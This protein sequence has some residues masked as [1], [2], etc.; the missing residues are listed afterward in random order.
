M[1]AYGYARV[2][3]N[4]QELGSQEA[5]LMAA[6][7]AK[8]FKEK[9]SGAKTD[10]AELAKVIRRLEAGDVLVVTR[11]DRLARSTHDLLNVL[12]TIGERQAS[13]RSLKDTWADTTTPHGRLMLT[14][15]GGLA[16]FERELIRART[17]DG[18]VRAKAR[19]VRFGRPAVLSAQ[20]RQE[21]IQRLAN[22]EAQADLARSYG[23]SQPTISRLRRTILAG[24]LA[25]PLSAQAQ[26]A[27]YPDTGQNPVERAEAWTRVLKAEREKQE[28]A[29]VQCLKT[30]FRAII[31]ARGL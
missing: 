8:V 20:Q 24:L 15:L 11:L 9:V 2:S 13:F 21:A 12:A 7:C 26:P 4:G 17:G 30:D 1:T 14:V 31:M 27:F 25:L 29:E 18:G 16:E 19:G 6:G 5:E 3:T 10:R 28:R 23:V 22:G